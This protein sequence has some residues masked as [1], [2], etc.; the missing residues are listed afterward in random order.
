M[1]TPTSSGKFQIRT[2]PD[3]HEA[4][5]EFSRLTGMSLNKFVE[6]SIIFA[7]EHKENFLKFSDVYDFGSLII[8]KNHKPEV[9][10]VRRNFISFDKIDNN[11]ICIHFK[12]LDP[13]NNKWVISTVEANIEENPTMLNK[14]DLWIRSNYEIRRSTFE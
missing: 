11:T 4:A 1:V 8:V 14:F 5:T 7:L 6:N 2:H 13:E 10:L 3:L 12:K 9:H